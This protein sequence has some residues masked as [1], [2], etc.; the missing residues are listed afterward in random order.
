[1]SWAWRKWWRLALSPS[2]VG[3]MWDVDG[4]W[5]HVLGPV[6]VLT[7]RG[8]YPDPLIRAAS[9]ADTEAHEVMVLCECGEL[10]P[11]RRPHG[12]RRVW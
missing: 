3:V 2:R 4:R 8:A 9:C 6:W 5:K 11:E 1:M 7:D 12:W 10:R